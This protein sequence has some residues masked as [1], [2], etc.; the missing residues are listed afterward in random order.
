MRVIAPSIPLNSFVDGI[1]HSGGITTL[2]LI[3]ANGIGSTAEAIYT[4][5]ET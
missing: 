2:G 4:A 3:G 1:D 5:T